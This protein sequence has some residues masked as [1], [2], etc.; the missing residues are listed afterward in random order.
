MNSVL[1]AAARE[2]FTNNS[3]ISLNSLFVSLACLR[4]FSFCFPSYVTYI[5]FYKKLQLQSMPF[6]K[7][8][9]WSAKSV[10]L[11]C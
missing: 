9:F 5:I 2:D 6:W 1:I 11:P 4:R 3:S 8:L 10:T 7:L